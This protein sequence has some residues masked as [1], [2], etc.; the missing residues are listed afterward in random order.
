MMKYRGFSS[1]AAYCAHRSHSTDESHKK[2]HNR[3][4]TLSFNFNNIISPNNADVSTKMR[5]AKTIKFAS[6]QNK[7]VAAR[8][9]V[10]NYSC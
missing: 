5:Y 2:E 4:P 8:V 10:S 6:S 9:S 7:S 1:L 3:C